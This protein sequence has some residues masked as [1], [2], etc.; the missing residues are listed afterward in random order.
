[1]SRRRALLTAALGFANTDWRC[2]PD[3][4]AALERYLQSWTGLADRHRRDDA[5][6][7]QRRAPSPRR[8]V[9]C[10]VLR[11]WPRAFDRVRHG[12]RSDAVACGVR[13]A[14]QA[15]NDPWMAA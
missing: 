14:W 5:A 4:A 1:M 15:I 2:R 7:F 8:S 6:G 13:A 12:D 3:A 11:R 10:D 9:A